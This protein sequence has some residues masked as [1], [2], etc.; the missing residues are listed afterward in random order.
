MVGDALN[1]VTDAIRRED[2]IEWIGVRHE[3]AGAFAASAQAQLTGRLGVCMGT[4]GP[5]AIHPPQRPV[6]RQEVACTRA[7]DLR[8][9]PASG[10]RQRLLPGGRQR[11]P[12]RGRRHVQPHR[13][14]HRP[15]AAVDRTGWQR[16]DPG[17]RG[18]RADPPGR[19]R[20]PRPAEGHRRAALR[21]DEA[22]L[23]AGARR[24]PAGRLV[25]QRRRQGDAFQLCYH[26]YYIGYLQKG[27]NEM[28]YVT[29]K[30]LEGRTEEREA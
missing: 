16:R 10:D 2:R 19:R 29:V 12:V 22:S 15:A 25:A 28:P 11:P 7:R 8:T 24:R 30:M 17:G 21:R 1:P 23:D 13:E 14:Q 6:Q 3:E 5:G 18:G 4:V 9:G 27:G 26:I 20:R